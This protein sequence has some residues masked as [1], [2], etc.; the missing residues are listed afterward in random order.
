MGESQEYPGIRETVDLP[1]L[2]K[3][4]VLITMDNNII[5][6]YTTNFS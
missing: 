3:R 1:P 4:P 5:G 6:W 2:Q